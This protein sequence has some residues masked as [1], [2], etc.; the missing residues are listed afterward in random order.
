MFKTL[1]ATLVLFFSTNAIAAEGDRYNF[2]VDPLDILFQ[3]FTM[4]VDR[5]ISDKW[6]LGLSLMQSVYQIS[7]NDAGT[8]KDIATESIGTGIVANWFANG[9]Y[10]KGLYLS[11]SIK[12][13]HHKFSMKDSTDVLRHGTADVVFASAMVGYGWFCETLNFM[14]GVGYNSPIGESKVYINDPNGQRSGISTVPSHMDLEAM[15]GWTF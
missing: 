8:S 11:P 5:K 6:T 1:L 12:Y 7:A 4:D 10:T 3:T 2:R 13:A 14:I 15:L 9:V